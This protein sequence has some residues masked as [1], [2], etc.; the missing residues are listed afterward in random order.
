MSLYRKG[1][2]PEVCYNWFGAGY[3]VEA[4]EKLTAEKHAL[5]FQF[6]SDGGA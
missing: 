3:T 5:R 4:P 2:K 6:D 1:G